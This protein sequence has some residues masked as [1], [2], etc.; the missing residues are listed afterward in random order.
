MNHPQKQKQNA[1]EKTMTTPQPIPD[2]WTIL[3][4]FIPPE[5]S[6]ALCTWIR[7]CLHTE[8]VEVT[9][10]ESRDT[11]VEL[12]F[13]DETRAL[14]AQ[15][16]LT[17]RYPSF[18][19]ALRGCR[20]R[21]WADFW[22]L[23]FK[24][25]TFGSRL[26][27]V[28]E[29]EIAP[30]SDRLTIRLEPGLSFGTGD[31]FTTGFCLEQLDW[32]FARE[33]PSTMLDAG[34]G[35]GILSIAAEKLGCQQID[36]FDF[37]P[38]C[39]DYTRKNLDLNGVSSVHLFEHDIT[40]GIPNGP[41]ELVCA[42]IYTRL[43]IQCAPAIIRASSRWLILTGIQQHES[44]QVADTYLRLGARQIT[45]DGSGEWCGMLMQLGTD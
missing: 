39:L 35:S 7:E 11:W 22:K 33:T 25:R 32:I 4:L 43:L 26:Q 17:S 31:H 8:P 20:Q 41:Y 36:A 14:L 28:P 9:R 44:D 16:L 34:T 18:P 2:Q 27:V 30:A 10:A 29:W 38:L 24:T 19:S 12:Y 42:N 23:H 37:D 45:W 3:S 40:Q 1:K 5:E 6:D 21:D 13:D 15:Q